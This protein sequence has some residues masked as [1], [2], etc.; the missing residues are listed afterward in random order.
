MK[1][2]RKRLR[3]KGF[4]YSENGYYFVTACVDKKIEYFWNPICRGGFTTLP[5]PQLNQFGKIVKDCWIDLPNHY[6]NCA[7]DEFVVMPN[8]IHGIVVIN[9]TR[10]GYKP[11]PTEYAISEIMRGFKTFSS[12]K[13]N[14]LPHSF[15]FK[16]QRSYYDHIIR[17]DNEFFAIKQ[18]IL[19]NPTNWDE[20]EYHQ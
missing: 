9:N 3:L 13:I 10:A 6:P 11:A 20:D 17:S 5:K 14:L 16:W 8:H 19:D 18:Y 1:Q 4:D 7:L 15:M 2:T 12:K